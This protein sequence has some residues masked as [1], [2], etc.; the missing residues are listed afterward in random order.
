LIELDIAYERPA[1]RLVPSR[2]RN[3][4]VELP[5]RTA[6]RARHRDRARRPVAL[7]RSRIGYLRNRLRADKLHT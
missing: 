5:E 4:S 1:L 2:P 3:P 6:H 7:P